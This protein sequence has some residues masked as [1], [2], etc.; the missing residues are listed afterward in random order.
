MWFRLTVILR[1]LVLGAAVCTPPALLGL[2]AGGRWG[3]AI[4]ALAGIAVLFTLAMISEQVVFN[5]H[6]TSDE[7][8]PGLGRSYEQV[9][10]QEGIPP[11]LAPGLHIF[12][13]P[14]PLAV[15]ARN[16]GSQGTLLVS[17]GAVSTLGERDLRDLLSACVRRVA[18]PWV[19]LATLTAVLALALSRAAPED[20]LRF[21][22]PEVGPQESAGAN[23]L[24]L[25]VNGALRLLVL[26][27][28]IRFT[29]R[30]GG[31]S[32]VAVQGT[33]HSQVRKGYRPWVR[34]RH[35]ALSHLYLPR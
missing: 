29:L 7:L 34:V 12:P 30:I 2:V 17:Q 23:R 15:L 21:L 20:W 3:A 1:W 22:Q 33:G 6:A 27:P 5:F 35:P 24:S 8:P 10:I 32:S 9:L 11:R 31:A 14:S 19:P 18:R 25:R 26:Y 16:P 13:D 28:F 4:G